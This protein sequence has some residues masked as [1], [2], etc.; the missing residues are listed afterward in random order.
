MLLGLAGQPGGL[1]LTGDEDPFLA[2]DDLREYGVGDR[3]GGRADGVLDGH[4]DSQS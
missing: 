2:G 1:G 3:A 4:D